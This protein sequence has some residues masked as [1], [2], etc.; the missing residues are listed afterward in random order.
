VKDLVAFVAPVLVEL[1][2]PHAPSHPAN[3]EVSS[4]VAVGVTPLPVS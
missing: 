4:G 1:D 2:P 3:V